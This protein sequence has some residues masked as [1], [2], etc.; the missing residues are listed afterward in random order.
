MTA[1]LTTFAWAAGAVYAASAL[2]LIRGL[3]RQVAKRSDSP[4]ISIVVPVRNEEATLPALLAS[5]VRLDYPADRSEVIIVNDQSSDRTRHVAESFQDKFPCNFRVIDVNPDGETLVAKTR[6]LAQGIENANHEFVLMTDA[7]CIVPRGW[8]RGMVQHFTDGVGMVCGMTIPISQNGL[9]PVFHQ[10]E[11]QDWYYLLGVAAGFAGHG[12]S[13]ALIGNNYAVRKATYDRLGGFRKMPFNK[14]DD[15]SLMSAI[16]GEGR[17]RVVMPAEQSVLIETQ[18][19]N[20]FSALVAQ[21]Q[22]WLKAWPYAAIETKLALLFGIIMHAS[23]PVWPV[24]FGW[25]TLPLLALLVISDATVV[26]AVRSRFKDRAYPAAAWLYP[27]FA[28]AYGMALVVNVVLG[29]RIHWK[30]RDF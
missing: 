14:I 8:A 25:S 10:L 23:V 19:V 24:L 26:L 3:R 17:E 21:R 5:L 1:L 27:L 6:P 30:D 9:A 18:P 15:I 13:Q 29:K 4:S 20:S 11:K 28:C 7:D 22:R 2:Y 16:R 12:N